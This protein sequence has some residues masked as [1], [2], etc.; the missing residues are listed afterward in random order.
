MIARP[1]SFLVFDQVTK[2]FGDLDV[3]KTPFNL[4]IRLNEFVTFL[5]PSGCGKTTL[6]RMVGGLD[7]ASGGRILLEGQ[8]VGKP[9]RQRGMV[10]QSYS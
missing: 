8:P 2:R 6:M 3:V 5:G 10:F 7:V 9:D 1:D 4:T